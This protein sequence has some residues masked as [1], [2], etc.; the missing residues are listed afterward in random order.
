MFSLFLFIDLVRLRNCSR[1]NWVFCIWFIDAV[2]S[3]RLE[4][5]FSKGAPKSNKSLTNSFSCKWTFIP[6][7][8]HSRNVSYCLRRIQLS[9][10]RFSAPNL[11]V[12][13]SKSPSSIVLRMSRNEERCCFLSFL[14]RYL[15]ESLAR[16]FNNSLRS[17]SSK[18][19]RSF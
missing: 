4:S 3:F 17:S 7:P 9:R 2:L 1:L 14:L 12:W 5:V 6:G 10:K 13:V 19:S 15:A 16:L 18:Q 11:I 8:R